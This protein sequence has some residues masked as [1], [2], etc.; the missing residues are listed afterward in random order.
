MTVW[1]THREAVDVARLKQFVL[2]A[3]GSQG[4]VLTLTKLSVQRQVHPTPRGWGGVITGLHRQ[5][6]LSPWKP[7]QL[8]S[9]FD[10]TL[11]MLCRT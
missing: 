11:I 1:G 6:E 8:V 9:E 10:L 3:G 5:T 4:D 2:G 7:Q